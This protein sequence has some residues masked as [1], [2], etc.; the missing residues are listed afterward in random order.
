M[1]RKPIGAAAVCEIMGWSVS[2]LERRLRDR[3]QD[4]PFPQPVRH[5]Q[6]SPRQWFEDEVLDWQDS[7][8]RVDYR[9]KAE[10][11]A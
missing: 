10:A 9:S 5:S 3:R 2:T 8:P 1:V 6:C 11:M 7:L 4:P